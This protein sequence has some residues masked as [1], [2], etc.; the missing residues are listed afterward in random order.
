[1]GDGQLYQAAVAGC[2]IWITSKPQKKGGSPHRMFIASFR[3]ARAKKCA[4]AT[5]PKPLAMYSIR[6]IAII[7]CATSMP[8]PLFLSA[9]SFSLGTRFRRINQAIRISDAKHI[10]PD[11]PILLLGPTWEVGRIRR[12]RSQ[13]A[14]ESLRMPGHVG[15]KHW[16]DGVMCRMVWGDC[17]RRAY[18]TA[19]RRKLMA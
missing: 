14:I 18:Q 13:N 17:R 3:L 2:N 12:L 6:R 8:P 9:L 7:V 1:M 4:S 16:H 11:A 5:T 15:R 10:D 19:T